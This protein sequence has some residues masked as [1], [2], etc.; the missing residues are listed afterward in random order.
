MIKTSIVRKYENGFSNRI[1]SYRIELKIKDEKKDRRRCVSINL[2]RKISIIS[3]DMCV[4]KYLEHFS[5][6]RKFLGNV[7]LPHTRYIIDV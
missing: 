2:S 5:S 4:K 7:Y 3:I 1:K 6:V